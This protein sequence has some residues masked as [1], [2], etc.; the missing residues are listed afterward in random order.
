MHLNSSP[1][2]YCTYI[3]TEGTRHQSCSSF[4]AQNHDFS[5]I[6]KIPCRTHYSESQIFLPKIF[7]NE[8]STFSKT[9]FWHENLPKNLCRVTFLV[10]FLYN[11]SSSLCVCPSHPVSPEPL[12][13][14][15][16]NFAC[17]IYSERFLWKKIRK[18][19][20]SIKNKC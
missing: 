10:L 8:N 16:W 12:D 15:S 11:K 5:R 9:I 13:L 2:Y 3:H 1:L 4:S 14:W 19:K 18:I 6:C 17:V 7:F 20:N